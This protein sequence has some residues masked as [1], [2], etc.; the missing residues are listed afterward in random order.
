[1]FSAFYFELLLPLLVAQFCRWNCRGCIDGRDFQNSCQQPNSGSKIW[2]CKHAFTVLMLPY[3]GPA[4]TEPDSGFAHT[5]LKPGLCPIAV[6]LMGMLFVTSS[7]MGF[8]FMFTIALNLGMKYSSEG[9]F[10][11]GLVLVSALACQVGGWCLL[12]IIPSRA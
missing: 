10:I 9:S 1:M 7:G 8:A 2:F 5:P 6:I 4:P 12:L 3:Q 11:G